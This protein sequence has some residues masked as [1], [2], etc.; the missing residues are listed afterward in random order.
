MTRGGGEGQMA[1]YGYIRVS[2]GRQAE[3]GESLAVQHRQ[4]EGCAMQNG[5]TIDRVFREEGI[6]GSVPVIDRPAGAEMMAAAKAGDTI[7]AAKLDR[8]FRSAL[9]ALQT[10]EML[11][12]RGVKLHLI[13]LGGDV[14]GNGMAKMFLTVAAAFAEAERGRI[15]ERI[16][17][18]KADQAARGR[19]LGGSIPFGF[20]VEDGALVKDAAQQ[21]AILAIRRLR[22]RSGLSLRAIAAD[23]SERFKVD[24]SHVTVARVL[25]D[26]KEAREASR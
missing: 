2:T 13:D 7:V 20:K 3:E 24:I 9:D 17:T 25:R 15:A 23:V 22:H 10:V 12:K 6:S 26:L 4:L 18:V 11:Q 8:M 19:F 5:W 16:A 1:V 21:K 14:S